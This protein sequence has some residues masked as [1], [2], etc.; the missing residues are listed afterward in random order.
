[1]TSGLPETAGDGALRG[2]LAH[3]I[4]HADPGHVNKMQTVGAGGI[5]AALPGARS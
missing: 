4:A 5:G 2:I 1:V 3:G